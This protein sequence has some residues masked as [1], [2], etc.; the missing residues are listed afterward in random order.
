MKNAIGPNWINLALVISLIT[1]TWTLSSIGYYDITEA[2]GLP[3]GYNDAPVLLSLYYGG[4]V[5]LVHWLFRPDFAAWTREKSPGEDRFAPLFLL[6]LFAVFS[7]KILPHLPKPDPPEDLA[8]ADIVFAQSWY[9]IPKTVEI[10]FQQILLT[11]LVIE[12]QAMKVGLGRMTVLIAGLFGGF[13]LSL[14][15]TGASDFYVARYTVAATLYGMV[16]PYLILHRRNGYVWAFG[17]HWGFYA[18]DTT[19]GHFA[20]AAPPP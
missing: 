1:A 17:L 16:F 3:H 15:L 4:W 18:F 7:L 14:A 13:H 19:M 6:V 8:V 11:A 9:F 5:L 20:F 12:F 10:L 2:F